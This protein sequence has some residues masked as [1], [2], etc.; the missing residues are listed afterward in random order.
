MRGP[1][2]GL[3]RGDA[4]QENGVAGTLAA[5]PG[6]RLAP[7][8]NAGLGQAA[9]ASEDGDALSDGLKCSRGVQEADGEHTGP[10]SRLEAQAAARLRSNA[11]SPCDARAPAEGELQGTG[12]LVSL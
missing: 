7:S 2:G 6:E 10:A 12:S 11:A 5:R 9:A 3:S 1:Q 8:G 4:G